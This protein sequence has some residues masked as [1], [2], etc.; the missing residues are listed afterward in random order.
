MLEASLKQFGISINLLINSIFKTVCNF[1]TLQPYVTY[2]L[3]IDLL[4]VISCATCHV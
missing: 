2:L 1:A 4:F 3:L